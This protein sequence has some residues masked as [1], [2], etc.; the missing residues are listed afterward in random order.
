[1]NRFAIT[2]F[3]VVGLCAAAGA[4]TVY[5]SAVSPGWFV[6][7]GQPNANFVVNSDNGVQ[8]GLSSFYRFDG[9][10]NSIVNNVYEFNSGNTYPPAGTAAWNVNFH[11]YLGAGSVATS[12]VLLTIDWD[13]TAGT[14]VHTY[15]LSPL[16]AYL[17]SNNGLNLLQ[18]SENLGFTYWN[19][20]GF[21]ALTGGTAPAVP[22]NPNSTGTYTFNLTITDLSGN[23]QSSV[24]MIVNVVPAPGAAAALGLGGLAA[25]RRR[26]R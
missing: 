11:A 17:S 26:R 24:D 9:G 21:L 20:P 19:D 13:P 5:N 18:G 1:M 7:T 12:N 6:G 2:S 16:F 10:Q 23:A 22:F 4:Q 3:A 25:L 8:T 14:D 15:N